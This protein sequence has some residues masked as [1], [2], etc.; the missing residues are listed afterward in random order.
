MIRNKSTF[1][2]RVSG[3]SGLVAGT[4]MLELYKITGNITFIATLVIVIIFSAYLLATAKTDRWQNS[5]WIMT[6]MIFGLIFASALQAIF[7]WFAYRS[8]K[9]HHK[10]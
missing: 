5:K 4:G 3:W 1:W 6:V 10:L 7:L 9:T 8:V 2:V